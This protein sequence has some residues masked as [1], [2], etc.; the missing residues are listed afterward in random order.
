M[1]G[2]REENYVTWVKKQ[3]LL[4]IHK[5]VRE[6]GWFQRRDVCDKFNVTLATASEDIKLF[7]KLFPG[8]VKYD[9]KAKRYVKS[10][11]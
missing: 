5:C 4:F 2:G 8:K 6:K 7:T 9:A 1:S 3:R 10:T 11:H